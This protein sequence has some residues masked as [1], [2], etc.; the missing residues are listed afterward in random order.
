MINEL[1]DN[2]NHD[3]DNND[4]NVPI[5]V[6]NNAE[7]HAR[8]SIDLQAD[9]DDGTGRALSTPARL[10]DKIYNNNAFRLRWRLDSFFENRKLFHR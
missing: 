6:N 9:D 5:D 10:K 4:D 8:P 7:A 3:D 2:N 1:K